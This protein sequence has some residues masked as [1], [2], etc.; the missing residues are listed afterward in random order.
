M[1][2]AVPI[3]AGETV[4]WF[5]GSDLANP[6]PGIV[7][8]VG[9]ETINVSVV[10]PNCLNFLVRDGVRHVSDPKAKSSEAADNGLWDYT[11]SAKRLRSALENLCNAA[12]KGK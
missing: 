10:V 7:T 6:S 5:S 8:S 4:L 9:N 1:S 2:Q 3:S 12:S 11:P